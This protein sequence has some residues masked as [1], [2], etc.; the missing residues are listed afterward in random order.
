MCKE[1]EETGD[2]LL[3]HCPV[4]SSLWQM[5]LALFGM[6]W[7]FSVSIKEVLLSWKGARIGKKKRKVWRVAPLCLFWVIWKERNRRAFEDCSWTEQRLKNS[8]LYLWWDWVRLYIGDSATSLVDFV[9]W[10]GS[11]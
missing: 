1:E 7:V 5:V 2:H 4:A 3:I 9:D 10:L 11:R 8:F 6:H